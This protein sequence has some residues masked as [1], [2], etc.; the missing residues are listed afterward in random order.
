MWACFHL[1]YVVIKQI[2]GWNSQ[3]CQ[4]KEDFTLGS[5]EVFYCIS[6]TWNH[7]PL[8]F[9]FPPLCV[10]HRVLRLC[11]ATLS[12]HNADTKSLLQNNHLQNRSHISIPNI[13]APAD[14]HY[15]QMRRGRAQLLQAVLEVIPLMV[16]SQ[17]IPILW[18][19]QHKWSFLSSIKEKLTFRCGS[20][21]SF[22]CLSYIICFLS[23]GNSPKSATPI[24]PFLAALC[25]Y[26]L[27][28]F[29]Y[30]FSHF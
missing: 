26:R 30:I 25:Y 14:S 24:S 8:P 22:L 2:L 9:P 15:V 10:L 29:Q 20:L 1:G 7:F 18:N 19:C 27:N 23:L 11:S 16:T 4:H 17:T 3:D 12:N 5:G 28:F 13:N 6:H 21:S